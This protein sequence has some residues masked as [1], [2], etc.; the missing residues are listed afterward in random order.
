MHSK[1]LR[2]AGAGAAF[3]CL[4]CGAGSNAF[5]EGHKAELRKDYDTALVKYD[6]ALQSQ[7]DNALY[8][9]HEKVARSR[10]SEFHVRQGRRLASA[11]RPE[12]AAGEFQK[13]ISI[14]PTNDVAGQELTRLVAA[15]AAAKKARE[16]KIQEAL[17][18]REEP[19]QTG[20]VK[21]KP[22]PPEPMVHFHLPGESRK[23]YETLA[24]VAELNIAFAADFQP[25]PITVDLSNVTVEQA[26]HVV[27]LQTH[28]F[29]KAVTPNTILVVN[30]TPTNHREYDDQVIKVVYLLNPLAAAD[31][32]AI[33]TAVKTLLGPQSGAQVIDNPDSNAIILQSTPDKVE[34]AE[35]MI[36]DLDRGKAE[37]LIE[38]AVVEADHD[39]LRDLGL[40][41]VWPQNA[42]GLKD[43]N[44]TGVALNSR[45]SGAAASTLSLKDLQRLGTGDFSVAVPAAVANALLSDSHTRILQ[46]PE[47]RVTDG[48]KASLKIG[49]RFPYATGSFAP[50]FGGITG[51]GGTGTAAQ[52]FGLLSSTQ[53]QYQDIGVIMD[54]QP[55]LLPDGEIALHAKI[56]ITS[57]GAT[58]A[59]GGLEQPTFG[60]R[61]IEHDIRLKESEVN[62]L[63]GLIEST[64]TQSVS[65]LPGL[66]QIPG[67]RYLFS[68]E[69]TQREDTEVLVMLTPRVIRLPEPPVG[70]GS[71][72]SVGA[73]ARSAE[74]GSMEAPQI[75]PT[76]PG[77][78]Q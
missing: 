36:H 61:T 38:V 24:K 40:R 56:E 51:T 65:G 59:V 10:A 67:L 29:W 11:G 53:F 64:R 77:T 32:T 45:L 66:G 27:A 48:A 75:P 18:T 25:R 42:L 62:L 28:T 12:D 71:A 35:K 26:L 44:I 47:V 9:L 30:D 15:Q 17:K 7:P 68:S 34:A 76:P 16:T 22:F 31:R 63:G 69:H 21:L 41:Q 49:S 13:A 58:V 78:P 19:E 73:G 70:R 2:F 60:Q 1:L 74:G 14:D 37:I 52:N 6:K 33:L 55:H 50:S 57:V 20:L 72:V 23:V 46:N 3:V 43:P 5:R 39:R 8:I 54:L 4:G